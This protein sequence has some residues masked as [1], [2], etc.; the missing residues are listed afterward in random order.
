MKNRCIISQKFYGWYQVIRKIV[1]IYKFSKGPKIDPYGTPVLIINPMGILTIN[2]TLWYSLFRKLWVSVSRLSET[3]IVF[4]LYI[5]PS[6]QPIKSF[7]HIWK[8][9][10]HF[11]RQKVIKRFINFMHYSLKLIDTYISFS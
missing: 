8:F 7:W 4:N 2:K 10:A 3:P 9:G 11:Q 1:Y 5:K 6:C